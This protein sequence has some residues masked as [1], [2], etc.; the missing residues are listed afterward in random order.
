MDDVRRLE[1]Q[2]AE[3]MTQMYAVGN[4]LARLRVRLERERAAQAT[5]VPPEVR[6]ESPLPIPGAVATPH[7]VPA[8]PPAMSAPS[9]AS[10]WWQREGAVARALAIA[11]AAVTLIG[12][13]LLITLA[14]Q[15]GLFGPVAR[16]S[17]GAVL[18][19]GLVLT[20]HRV[21]R[22]IATQSAGSGSRARQIGAGPR[23]RARQVGAVAIAGTGFAAAYLDVMA[24]AV[25]YGWVPAGVGLALAGAIGMTGLLLAIV[26]DSQTLALITVVG[27]MAL[28]PVIGG[29][30]NVTTAAFLLVMT[31]VAQPAQV[32][33][34]W[35]ALHAA[36]AVPT[37]LLLLAG[38]A[39]GTDRTAYTA[40][41]VTLAVFDLVTTVTACRSRAAG[42]VLEPLVVLTTAPAAVLA[43]RQPHWTATGLLAGLAVAHLVSAVL[44]GG[45]SAGA[46]LRPLL[47]ATGSSLAVLTVVE[48]TSERLTT[49]GLVLLAIGYASNAARARALPPGRRSLWVRWRWCPISPSWTCC[50]EPRRGGGRA[51]A[52]GPARLP[53]PARTGRDP[54]PGPAR[55]DAAGRG[56]TGA[57]GR[58]LGGRPA[59]QHRRVGLA[60][61]AAGEA[62]GRRRGA[63]PSP[64]TTHA[65]TKGPL[66]RPGGVTHSTR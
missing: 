14:V 62:A 10:T 15:L 41:A 22:G 56:P 7:S 46:R 42:A 33:R 3:A 8:A 11:G 12:V 64:S 47:T 66:Q 59:G 49:T 65:V 5:A 54:G 37:A 27:V 57:P 43:L 20:G 9:P 55:P 35:P 17:A 52:G 45:R 36:R 38:A 31:M 29:G 6:S 34:S 50:A 19:L 53:A 51:V 25:L 24:V 13:A 63:R 61:S 1:D 40:L 18:A 30:V 48:G 60:R 16:V 21:H 26:W 39:A 23:S 28:G 32:A 58:H 2:F 4:D 44:A